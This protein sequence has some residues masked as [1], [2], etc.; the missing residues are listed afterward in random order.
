MPPRPHA[1][2]RPWRALRGLAPVRPTLVPTAVVGLVL[3]SLA[4]AAAAA[5]WLWA[6]GPTRTNGAAVELARMDARFEFAAGYVSEQRVNVITLQ[7]T[8]YAQPAGLPDCVTSR[9][10][11][12]A[13]VDDYVYLSAQRRF[14]WRPGARLRPVAGLGAVVASERNPYV[15][16]PLTFSLSA[17]LSLGDRV[18]LEW[19]H[20]SNA[21][22][23]GP[24][25]GQDMLLLRGRW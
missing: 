20:F 6:A 7:D 11:S 9:T 24:N 22:I 3:A 21:G 10:R 2:F 12:R 4:P 13:S 17:G 8:C 23:S 5:D 15:S 1:T 18:T 19:R 14:S 16:S 25:L